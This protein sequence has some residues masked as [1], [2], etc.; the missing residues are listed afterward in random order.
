MRPRV[1]VLGLDCVPPLLAFE[2]YAHVMPHLSALRERGISGPLRSIEPPITVPAWACMT[3]GRDPGEL[4]IY[5][6]RDRVPGTYDLSLVDATRISFPRVWEMLS[7]HGISTAA[8]FVP[9][10]YPPKNIANGLEFGCFL[11][12]S[13][14]HAW[15]SDATWKEKLETLHGPYLMDVA[16]IR[17][18]DRERIERELHA[19]TRQH[20]AM[21]R[22]VWT[23]ANPDFLMMVDIG[24]DRFHHAFWSHLE[25]AGERYYSLL[26]QEIGRAI[27]FTDSNTTVIIASDHGARDMLG[28]VAINEWLIREGFL[29]LLEAPT[30]AGPLRSSMVDWQRTKAW[31]EG[32]YY[33]RIFLN[34]RGREPHGI[35]DANEIDNVS[36]EIEARLSTMRDPLGAPLNNRV[37]RPRHAYR[38]SHGLPP[39]LAV[40][41]GDLAYRS[42]A[43]VGSNEIFHA[44]N[45]TGVDA[46]NHDWNGIFVMSGRRAPASVGPESFSL[47]DITRTILSLFDI[48]PA[49]DLLGTDRSVR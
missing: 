47:Y 34:V 30:N 14:T 39:D 27:E 11:T 13:A 12:P 36:N 9:P 33:G 26:D 42:L 28:G 43:I 19:M 25:N 4:G 7:Q 31:G 18:G 16:D 24:P 6:F 21:A 38:A 32:G 23:Q 48:E 45:D 35:V 5:G 49:H 41:W 29:T 44:H 15:A 8:L 2:R 3:T 20:F 10:T 22:S 37:M 46:C 1:L 17:S 40:F